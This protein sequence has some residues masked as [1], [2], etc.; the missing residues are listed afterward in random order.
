MS[1]LSRKDVAAFVGWSR[2]GQGHAMWREPD[3]L[4]VTK[5]NK[6]VGYRSGVVGAGELRRRF[7]GIELRNSS[8]QKTRQFRMVENPLLC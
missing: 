4:R 5:G 3:Q 1:R 2:R 6:E 7:E 8:W